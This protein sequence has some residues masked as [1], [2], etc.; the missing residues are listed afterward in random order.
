MGYNEKLSERLS[1]VGTIDPYGLVAATAVHSDIVDMKKHRRAIIALLEGKA[2]ATKM[3]A[4]ALTIQVFECT[5]AG[6]A[7]TTALK[8]S[9]ITRAQTTA[10]LGQQRVLE[11][12]D[13]ELGTVHAAYNRY[14]KVTVTP[15]T[16]AVN[17]GLVILAGDSRYS[18]PATDD[19]STNV[20]V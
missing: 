6:T 8:T 17:A 16:N 9:T 19:L 13:T 4:T 3:A 20:I 5:A 10:S 18:D 14:F 2:V 7:A 12:R 11:V 15:G 1:L